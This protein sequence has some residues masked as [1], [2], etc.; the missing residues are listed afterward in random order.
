MI[1]RCSDVIM[2]V[3]D[4][5]GVIVVVDGVFGVVDVIVGGRRKRISNG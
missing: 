2:T 4:A 3:V 5:A 1:F